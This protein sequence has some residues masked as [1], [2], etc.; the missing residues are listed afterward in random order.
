MIFTRY[1]YIK[2]EVE[3]ALLISL[4]KRDANSARFWSKE[5]AGEELEEILLAGTVLF[6][7]VLQELFHKNPLLLA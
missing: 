6:I 4:L 5:L 3:S 2:E 7:A 1:L